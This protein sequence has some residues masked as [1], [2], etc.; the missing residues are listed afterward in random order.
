VVI[1]VP[2]PDE[3]PNRIFLLKLVQIG[4]ASRCVSLD[5]V[6]T[7][8]LAG[9]NVRRSKSKIQRRKTHPWQR[10]VQPSKDSAE[11][12]GC[13]IGMKNPINWSRNLPPHWSSI[14]SGSVNWKIKGSE[15]GTLVPTKSGFRSGV[16]TPEASGA[17]ARDQEKRFRPS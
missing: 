5:R 4:L 13:S 11:K 12:Q 2:P 6:Q 3:F 15:V 17:K 8:L 16:L 14:D 7:P 1:L 10:F 9:W